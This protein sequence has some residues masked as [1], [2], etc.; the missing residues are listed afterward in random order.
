[1]AKK[2]NGIEQ[3]IETAVNE[4]VPLY[5]IYG[6]KF[7]FGNVPKIVLVSK[8]LNEVKDKMKEIIENEFDSSKRSYNA[9][10]INSVS[11]GVVCTPLLLK[12]NEQAKGGKQGLI[13][14]IDELESF[15]FCIYESAETGN[16]LIFESSSAAD[17]K[18]TLK[19]IIKTESKA[20]TKSNKEYSVSLYMPYERITR[21]NDFITLCTFGTAEITKG[22]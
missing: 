16:A 17:T 21:S 19:R 2:P 8:N 18:A 11:S 4:A 10:E 20:E 6:Y 7:N 5:I 1:M 9:Y 14:S 3:R 22:K 15:S 12:L 13:K